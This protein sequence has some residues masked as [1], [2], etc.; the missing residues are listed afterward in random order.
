MIAVLLGVL[1]PRLAQAGETLVELVARVEALR[2]ATDY[3]RAAELA[4]EGAGRVD[5][6]AGERVLLGGLAR[7]NF[8]LSYQAGGP[9]TD[10]CELA[11]VM[12]LVAPLDSA[13]GSA[14]KLA[15]AADAEAR[16]EQAVGAEWP[17][18]CAPAG[19]PA[20]VTRDAV[21]TLVPAGRSRADAE[22]AAPGVTQRSETP[23]ADRSD[24]R[25]VRAGVGTL[26]S[27]LVLFAPMAGVLA[28]RAAGERELAAL[29]GK[30]R[31]ATEEENADAV[32]LDQRHRAAT[33][34]AV[35]LGV[36]GAAL[37]VTGAVLLAT[38][39]RKNRVAVAPWG[40]RGLGGLVLEGSF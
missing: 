4:A 27:G 19:D 6:A 23:R 39:G 16:L 2:V 24:R 11:A 31:Q 40:A 34:G 38:G 7:Q 33:A 5:L 32:A 8:E 14:V 28:Y 25:R 3:A 18:V 15:A 37:A 36:T 1:A 12:R 35:V 13:A 26:V 29:R 22:P 21:P 20:I 9:L 10:L 30:G 17:A